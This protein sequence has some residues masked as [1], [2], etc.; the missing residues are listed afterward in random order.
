MGRGSRAKTV[1]GG[2]NDFIQAWGGADTLT[3]GAGSDTFV[4]QIVSDS[5]PEAPD[6][7]TDY[8]GAVDWLNLSPIDA[9]FNVADNQAFTLAASA[10]D[11]LA[12]A[13]LAFAS[14]VTTLSLYMNGDALADMVITF[15]GDITANTGQFVL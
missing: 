15:T 10:G 3:G 9:N 2:G 1:L 4:Y 14:G 11:G 13:V 8:D 7:I 12:K 6:L 5:T